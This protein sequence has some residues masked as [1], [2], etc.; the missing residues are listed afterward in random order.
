MAFHA[1]AWSLCCCW[2][3]LANVTT[4]SGTAPSL[5]ATAASMPAWYVPT[6]RFSSAVASAAIFRS[7]LAD[8]TVVVAPLELDDLLLDPH[9]ASTRP[10]TVSPAPARNRRRVA[11]APPRLRGIR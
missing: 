8:A 9:A 6:A 11:Q 7:S 4:A 2:A 3:V 1:A 5:P 10:P